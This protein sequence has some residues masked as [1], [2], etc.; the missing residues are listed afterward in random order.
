MK[1]PDHLKDQVILLENNKFKVKPKNNHGYLPPDPR[2]FAYI[3]EIFR[4][5]KELDEY[6][7][8]QDC[9]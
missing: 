3:D 4:I 8:T 2:F 9:D 7:L 5:A 1:I 6:Q